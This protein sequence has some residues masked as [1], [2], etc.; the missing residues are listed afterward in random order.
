MNKFENMLTPFDS[1]Y[2]RCKCSGVAKGEG[3]GGAG[4][5]SC[6]PQAPDIV[7]AGWPGWIILGEATATA[8][9]ESDSLPVL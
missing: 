7:G 2:E 6:P 3:E 9:Q 4:R 5:D 1:I 8:D